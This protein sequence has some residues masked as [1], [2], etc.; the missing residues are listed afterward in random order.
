MPAQDAEYQGEQAM[1]R[2]SSLLGYEASTERTLGICK[3]LRVEGKRGGKSRK[4]NSS[5]RMI[6]A[7]LANS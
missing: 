3:G 7:N 2:P 4:G 5:F 1:N 6:R